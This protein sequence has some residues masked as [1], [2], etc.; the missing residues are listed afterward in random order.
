MAAD[1]TIR[2]RYPTGKTLYVQIEAPDGTVWNGTA[3]ATLTTAGWTTFATA[4]TE[5]PA[6]SGR[7]SANFPTA[8]AAG[9]YSWVVYLQSGGSP[10]TSDT[11]IAGSST[12]SYWDGTTFGGASSVTGSVASVLSGVPAN[13]IHSGTAR[14][15]TSTTITLDTGASSVDNTYQANAVYL[16]GGTG[17]GQT[18]VIAYNGYVGWTRVATMTTPWATT[19]DATTTFQILPQGGVI[20]GAIGNTARTVT[21]DY[22]GANS[23]MVNNSAGNPIQGATVNAYLASAYSSQGS[24]AP[25]IATTTTDASGHW[26]L[27]LSPSAYTLTFS[28]ANETSTANVTV[29]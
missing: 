18:G 15:G 23:L 17:A 4:M 21:Q 8:S 16:S 14:G 11:P 6:G 24:G 26:S 10:A 1:T 28:F 22:L 20:V 13:V 2:T 29:N 25:V 9:N 5:T 3:Y 19:P 12:G 27:S 7:Y